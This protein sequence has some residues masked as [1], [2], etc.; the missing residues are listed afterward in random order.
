MASFEAELC[1]GSPVSGASFSDAAAFGQA[2]R[3]DLSELLTG[4]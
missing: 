3:E 2:L 4:R 1:F